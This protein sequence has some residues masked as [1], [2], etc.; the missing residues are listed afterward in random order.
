MDFLRKSS[1]T[2]SKV[3]SFAAA[4]SA[5]GHLQN[6]APGQPGSLA[7]RKILQ[8]ALVLLHHEH[9]RTMPPSHNV[10]FSYGERLTPMIRNFR[11]TGYGLRSMNPA[12]ACTN[13][14]T[15]PN[16]WPTLMS[17]AFFRNRSIWPE[18]ARYSAFFPAHL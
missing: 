14:D 13:L 12:L 11:I 1:S 16:Q 5:H 4:C 15:V 8:A 2:G 7:H 17:C 6:S 18:P 10:I 3:D 9:D